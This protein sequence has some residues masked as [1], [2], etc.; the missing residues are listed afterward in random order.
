ME[1]VGSRKEGG[2]WEVDCGDMVSVVCVI[3]KEC[4]DSI[5]V[6]IGG[7]EGG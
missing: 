3:E 6:V 1:G 7:A 2:G 5:R 4:A